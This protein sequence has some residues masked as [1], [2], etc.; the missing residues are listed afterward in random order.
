[1]LSDFSV[2]TSFVFVVNFLDEEP[3]DDSNTEGVTDLPDSITW[4]I[5]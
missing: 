5:P 4:I 1:M 3:D 2:G